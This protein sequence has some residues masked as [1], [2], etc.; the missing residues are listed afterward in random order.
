[1]LK[2]SILSLEGGLSRIGVIGVTVMAFLSGYG[3]VDYPYSNLVIFL[4]PI[5]E[6][7]IQILGVQIKQ[8]LQKIF[9]KKKL[10]ATEAIKNVSKR[11]ATLLG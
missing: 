10:L 6:E 1:M 11:S 5:D 3:A 9:D 4:N 8:T 2:D 7:K